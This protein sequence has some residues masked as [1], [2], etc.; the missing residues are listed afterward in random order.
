MAYSE[1]PA[2]TMLAQTLVCQQVNLGRMWH[3]ET[4]CLAVAMGCHK[5]VLN[6][7][8]RAWLDRRSRG[9]SLQQSETLS[10]THMN[11][12]DVRQSSKKHIDNNKWSAKRS[13]GIAEPVPCAGLQCKLE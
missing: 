9:T 3:C 1:G 5:Q 13:Q 11:A 6:P 10:Q 7:V 12:T 8:L 4:V 2:G